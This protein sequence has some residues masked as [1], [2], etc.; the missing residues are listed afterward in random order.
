[1]R[2]TCHARGCKVPCRPQYLMCPRHWRRV[3]PTLQRA[4]WRTYREGQCDDKNPS[5]AWHKAA[6]AAIGYVA[7]LE[8]RPLLIREVNALVDY[9]FTVK[10][11]KGG[12]K[13]EEVS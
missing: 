10:G 3:H 2:H 7:S 13:V 5:E 9:G 1:M 6:D 11:H 4:V 8:D 12:L